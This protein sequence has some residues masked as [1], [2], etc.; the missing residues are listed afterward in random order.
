LIGLQDSDVSEL[1]RAANSVF[2]EN[3]AKAEDEQASDN[4]ENVS[5]QKAMQSVT[6]EGE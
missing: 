3:G 6:V 5:S 2:L 1:V 4:E